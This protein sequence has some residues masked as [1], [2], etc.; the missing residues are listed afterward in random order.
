MLIVSPLVSLV[1]STQQAIENMGIRS[2]AWKDVSPEEFIR[3]NELDPVTVSIC[4]P[5]HLLSSAWKSV[6]TDVWT[7]DFTTWDEAQCSVYWK[8]RAYT[9]DVCD[10]FRATFTNCKHLFTSATLGI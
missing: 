4:S 6:L 2:L 1:D 10:W 8:F 5:E 9:S 7:P 3:Q